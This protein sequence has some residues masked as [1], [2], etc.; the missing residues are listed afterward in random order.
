VEVRVDGLLVAVLV[1]VG[2]LVGL[3]AGA[4]AARRG[5]GTALEARLTGFSADLDRRLEAL[6]R[7]LWT[8]LDMVQHG[9]ADAASVAA[10]VRERIAQLG[11]TAQQVLDQGREL[12]KLGDLLRPPQARGAFGE[13][14]LEQVLTQGLPPGTWRPQHG[15]RSGVRVDAAIT[16]GEHLVPV[17]AKFPLDAFA[18][19]TEPGLDDAGRTAWR[20]SFVR[21]ARRHVDAIADKDI[22][23]DEGTLDFALCYV[24]SEAVYYEFLRD[25]QT[26][27]SVFR[28]AAGRRVFPVSPT[29]LYAY[30]LSVGVGLRGLRVEANARRILDALQALS[31]DL[32]RFRAEFDVVGRHLVN[33][34]AK[35]DEAIRR[36]DRFDAR[37]GEIAERADELGTSQPREDDDPA[38][39]APDRSAVVDADATVDAGAGRLTAAG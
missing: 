35:W 3:L 1:A 4:L 8:G 37:L 20:R 29:T 26:G 27:E 10:E 32:D 36:L 9:Q 22:C 13:L 34:R 24:P 17:D 28:Y 39:D 15:F 18:R 38:P 21:D 6:D 14:L 5:G 23:P 25:D 33:A 12:G 30:L 19:M 16:V 31:G 7:R 11:G 2:A